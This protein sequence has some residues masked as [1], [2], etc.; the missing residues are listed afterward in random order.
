MSHFQ[1][2]V[3]T[4]SAFWAK[5]G[6]I[7]VSPYDVEKGAGTSN[8]A[9]LMRSLGPE[10]FSAAYIEP[11]RRPTDGRYGTNPNRVQHYFQF[12]AI[13]KPSPDDIVDI[14]LDSLKEIGLDSA[15]HDIRF[16]HDDWENPTVGAWGL[17]WEVWLNGMEITQFTYF[18]Q[19][20]GLSLP[21]ITGEITYGIERIAMY[22]QNVDS[23][24]DIQWNDQLTYGDLFFENEVQWSK[25]NFESQ[26]SRMWM[27][28]FENFKCEAKRLID[29]GL[30]IPAYDFVLKSSHAF[31]M[32]DARGVISVSER[33]SYI[34]QIRE[35]AKGVADHYLALREKLGFP[36]LK[37]AKETPKVEQHLSV[38]LPKNSNETFVFE[39]RTEELPAT[40]VPI[41]IDQLSKA[42]SLFLQK[43]NLSY[44]S[45]KCVGAPR[46]LAIIIEDLET[47][48][49]ESTIE[50]RGPQQSVMWDES[51]KL[52][53][54]GEGF[55]RSVGLAPCSKE[56]SAPELSIQSVNG[57]DYVFATVQT[58]AI[59]TAQLLHEHL[60]RLVHSLEFPKMMRWGNYTTA[61]ARPI[62]SLLA[63]LGPDVVP[64]TLEYVCSD[65]Y[66]KGHRQLCPENIELSH[67][68]EYETRLE[69]SYV[70][71]DP[72]R[73]KE[74][75][76]EQVEHI[77]SSLN[78]Q[79]VQK[80]KVFAQLVHLSEW[81]EAVHVSF[82]SALLDAPKE[83]LIS[84]M[85][86]HQKYLPLVNSHGELTNH[87]IIVAD[88]TPSEYIKKGNVKVLSARLADGSFL[89]K[90]DIKTSLYDLR[91]KLH[92]IVYQRALGSVW[93]KTERLCSLSKALHSLYPS[94]D[95]TELAE[96]AKL[97]KTDLA[98]QVVGEFPDL[99]G[100]IGAL[101]AKEQGLS[102]A[103]AD[104]IEQHWLPKQ[105][106]GALAS[107]PEGILLSL[108][109]KIDS[110]AGFFA[111]GLQPSS[112]SDPYALRRQ[113]IGLIR[114]LISHTIHMPLRESFAHALSLFDL[115]LSTEQQE[116]IIEDLIGFISKRA[117]S[118]FADSG[119][120]EACE[121]VLDRQDNDIYD[122][123]LRL[124]AIEAYP[125]EELASFLEVLKRCY[126]QADL[127]SSTDIDV[128]LLE[129]SCE[130]ELFDAIRSAKQ[131]I[132]QYAQRHLWTQVLESLTRL[133]N[134]I[135][136]LFEQVKV[137]ADDPAV[138]NNR[139]ALLAAVI[140]LCA[141]FADGKKLIHS[142][143]RK[144]S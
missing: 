80:E 109:D 102:D 71:V 24:F 82:D 4:L 98:S 45:I 35:L 76:L 52:T 103:I 136:E 48:K 110:L 33:A 51:G 72:K 19:A 94:A 16:V 99:Q 144:F 114:T 14:Y 6:C 113:A 69:K 135:N 10:P 17:G 134:P 100:R 111:V 97:S 140:E 32:L 58:P 23:I 1:D 30:P 83:V 129:S 59:N 115:S 125:K 93:Q 28:H 121:A 68:K 86:E 50:K 91:D 62:R 127:C 107:T 7:I 11:C 141:L 90:E 108:S 89:W 70:L 92:T 27:S 88:N 56:A 34:G 64:V 22:L 77:E 40:F 78:L 55:L 44:T 9:T 142:M 138:R 73:R 120:K 137:L 117:I 47:S 54:A 37:Y 119:S 60:P 21:S 130:K 105:E 46:R 74:R 143:E 67:A 61:F 85:V 112:S 84:E 29:L 39:I 12:Q 124:Q 15:Q 13:L 122:A 5:H 20:A 53:K 57:N 49:P 38:P 139:L 132:S 116:K 18:Q 65:R 43:H 31:N 75:L 36:L 63:L 3:S 133:R 66:T 79:A 41:G 26:D 128:A 2:I 123:L 126:G 106:E 104:A 101:L 95:L 81:P 96:A 8:P 118:L 131:E 25:Y 87:F 42:F